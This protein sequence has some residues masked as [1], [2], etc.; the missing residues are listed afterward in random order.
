M[1]NNLNKLLPLFL[2]FFLIISV[3]VHAR[4]FFAGSNPAQTVFAFPQDIF[5]FPK[6]FVFYYTTFQQQ[7]WW[8]DMDQPDLRPSPTYLLTGEKIGVKGSND[9]FHHNATLNNWKNTLGLTWTFSKD[10]KTRLD[11]DYAYT[12]LMSVAEG[13]AKDSLGNR[14]WFKYENELAMHDF[15]LTSYWAYRYR[16][17]PIGFKVGGGRLSGTQPRLKWQ[18]TENDTDYTAQRQMWAWSA[19]QGGGVFDDFDGHERARSQDDYTVGSLYR[20][21][22]QAAATLEKIKF[23][24][25]F[26]RNFG[27]LDHYLW[28]GDTVINKANPAGRNDLTGYYEKAAAKKI[29]ETTFRVYGNYN[30]ITGDKY[31]F[32]TLVLTR[33][34]MMDSAGVDPLNPDAETGVLE[35]SHNFVFQINPNLNLYPWDNKYAYIDLAI[36]CNY[37]FV[38]YNYTRPYWVGGGQKDSYVSTRVQPGEDYSWYECSYARQ[39]FFEVALDINPTFPLYGDKEQ[40]LAA[41]LSLLLWTRFKWQNKYY[42]TANVAGSDV[43]F[44]VENTRKNFEREVWLN[45]TANIIYRREPY[46]IR[47]VLGQPLTYSLTP[48]T[49]VFDASGKTL[50]SHVQHENMWVS[51]AGALVGLYVSTTLSNLLGKNMPPN[52]VEK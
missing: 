35:K 19:L 31:K 36:L 39:N 10:L 45:M 22:I 37:S 29:G 3:S 20:F 43:S 41:N 5:L 24:A 30:W 33:Y 26:R 38:A 47:L 40:S 9:Y 16:D 49:S 42:G 7:P 34:T 50:V 28:E 27:S 44:E 51:Q 46:M 6:D 4:V 13:A 17:V 1:T 52:A 8:G 21:D 12:P 32:N 15:Y 25:R 11:I 18:I 48:S 14:L 23:G 2:L